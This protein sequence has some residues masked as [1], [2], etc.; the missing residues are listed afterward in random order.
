MRRVD[1]SPLLGDACLLSSSM[2]TFPTFRTV[3][4]L[5]MTRRP[6]QPSP[7]WAGAGAGPRTT[8]TATASPTALR[9]RIVRA[10]SRIKEIE[11]SLPHPSVRPSPRS[12]KEIPN[13]D[14]G[15]FVPGGALRPPRLP[16]RFRLVP[17]PDRPRTLF[18]E[19]NRPRCPQSI[20]GMSFAVISTTFFRGRRPD[21][22][23]F[24]LRAL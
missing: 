8:S 15:Q 23:D 5:V 21:D 3:P 1:R 20:R 9:C 2:T 19:E 11:D 6:I 4:N 24:P 14:A 10:P 18:E 7:S 17:R 16:R 22:E 13:Y 12:F